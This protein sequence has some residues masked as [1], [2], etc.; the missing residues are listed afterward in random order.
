MNYNDN[1]KS[2]CMYQHAWKFFYAT[3][4]IFKN[5]NIFFRTNW[6]FCSGSVFI[7]QIYQWEYQKTYWP[8]KRCLKDQISVSLIHEKVL[9]VTSQ[10]NAITN[11]PVPYEME[12]WKWAGA[13][14]NK[15]ILNTPESNFAKVLERSLIVFLMDFF[16]WYV[17]FICVLNSLLRKLVLPILVIVLAI[18]KFFTL[19]REWFVLSNGDKIFSPSLWWN[20]RTKCTCLRL[21][22]SLVLSF[23]RSPN[24]TAFNYSTP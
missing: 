11:V 8:I 21:L 12:N 23:L 22:K 19:I 17:H 1:S 18:L 9:Q 4:K 6:K 3:W 2:D 20:S 10:F 13:P 7:Y 15:I 24:Q 16:H 14:T 5:H